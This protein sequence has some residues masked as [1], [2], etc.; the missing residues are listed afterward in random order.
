MELNILLVLPSQLMKLFCSWFQRIILHISQ[1]VE[2]SEKCHRAEIIFMMSIFNRCA[3]SFLW[4]DQIYVIFCN[5][6]KADSNSYNLQIQVA[7][8]AKTFI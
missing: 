7:V 3:Q 2:F 5:N 4:N 8:Y 6:Q 1:I